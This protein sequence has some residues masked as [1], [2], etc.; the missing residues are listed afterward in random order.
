VPAPTE[1]TDGLG[2]LLGALVA[3]GTPIT[4]AIT[5]LLALMDTDPVA[6]ARE[7]ADVL[8]GMAAHRGLPEA[9]LAAYTRDWYGRLE[10]SERTLW[11][12][13]RRRAGGAPGPPSAPT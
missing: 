3:R 6:Y 13:W 2:A 5:Q 7:L 9:A 1:L 8:P 10:R 4:R 11:K 12:I